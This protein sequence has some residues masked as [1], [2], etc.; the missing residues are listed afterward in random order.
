LNTDWKSYRGLIR[1]DKSNRQHK[2]E[3]KW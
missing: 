1:E 2:E 3:E